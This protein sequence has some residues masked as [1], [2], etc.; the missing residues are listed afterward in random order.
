MK[1]QAEL[2][3]ISAQEW[4]KSLKYSKNKEAPQVIKQ[5]AEKFLQEKN[6]EKAEECYHN[7]LKLDNNLYNKSR[8]GYVYYKWEKY[9]LALAIFLEMPLKNFLIPSFIA[10]V[11]KSAKKTNQQKK[12]IEHLQDLLE[13]H[14]NAKQL[15]GAIKKL[16]NPP[17]SENNPTDEKI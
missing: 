7:V 11:I 1:F 9:D 2:K 14:P 3:G 8:L 6:F 10:M 17:V 5:L 15:W 4:E 13:K 16:S 12:V